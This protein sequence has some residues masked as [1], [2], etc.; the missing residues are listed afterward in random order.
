MTLLSNP[1]RWILSTATLVNVAGSAH[2]QETASPEPIVAIIEPAPET[3]LAPAVDAVSETA[4]RAISDGLRPS[5]SFQPVWVWSKNPGDSP[6]RLEQIIL[7]DEKPLVAELQ[8]IVDD[9]FEAYINNTQV[10][11]GTQWTELQRTEVAHVL[12]PGKNVLCL[13]CRNANASS[14]AGAI[15]VLRIRKGKHVL[16]TGTSP[17]T[18]VVY[19]SQ[20]LPTSKIV[21]LPAD[22]KP[23]NIFTPEPAQN[24]LLRKEVRDLISTIG[25]PDSHR[26]AKALGYLA[27]FAVDHPKLDLLEPSFTLTPETNVKPEPKSNPLLDLA[28]QTIMAELGHGALSETSQLRRDAAIAA[29][30]VLVANANNTRAVLDAVES[31]FCQAC[32]D[33]QSIQLAVLDGLIKRINLDENKFSSAP[34]NVEK[35]REAM[36]KQITDQIATIEN[37]LKEIE[38][39]TNRIEALRKLS[40]APGSAPG[41]A[42]A[43]AAEVLTKRLEELLKRLEAEQMNL[44]SF[45]QEL[46]AI[47]DP[48]VSDAARERL[49]VIADFVRRNSCCV[50]AGI[51]SSLV[52]QIVFVID[53]LRRRYDK[54]ESYNKADAFFASIKSSSKVP[55]QAIGAVASAADRPGGSSR[56]TSGERPGVSTTAPFDPQA[57]SKKPPLFPVTDDRGQRKKRDISGDV[58][59]AFRI[60]PGTKGATKP[61]RN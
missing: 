29:V 43:R 33:R 41:S 60:A 19:Q 56:F 21:I 20:R 49:S 6:L 57:S 4:S 15:A 42:P 24:T 14:A 47:P 1:L 9:E 35:A 28:L 54:I 53:K 16:V 18:T 26:A 12:K 34:Q 52:Q 25:S 45:Q 50:Q 2:A 27:Q 37:T 32:D 11:K 13:E 17:S 40:T 58:D 36:R 31:S 8:V 55:D 61:T 44:E 7:L 51:A 10:S 46:D 30:F 59:N 39:T 23:W 3:A 48:S 22:S 38:K 5:A